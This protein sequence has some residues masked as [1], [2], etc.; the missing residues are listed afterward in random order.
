MNRQQAQALNDY[1]HT[2]RASSRLPYYIFHDPNPNERN[3]TGLS[4]IDK[5]LEAY[6]HPKFGP[7][8]P[9][10]KDYSWNWGHPI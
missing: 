7:P 2:E 6:L 1:F 10:T 5:E 9:S 3:S 8:R 4:N